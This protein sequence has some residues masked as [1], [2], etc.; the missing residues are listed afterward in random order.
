MNN[1]FIYFCIIGT[2]IENTLCMRFFFF[3]ILFLVIA[4]VIQAQN[5]L[6][7]EAATPAINLEHKYRSTVIDGD[8][9]PVIDLRTAVITGERIF[10]DAEEER[11]YRRLVRDVRK[12][13]PFAKIAGNR[14]KE[15]HALVEDKNRRQRKKL[16]K[17]AENNLK[18]EFKKDL[19]NLT[20]NQG[21]ILM[22][23]IDRET[24]NSSYDL[25]KIYR[26][27]LSAL[28]WQSFAVIYDDKL[29]MKVR[30]D[31]DGEDKLIE[32][33]VLM[34]DRQEL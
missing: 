14:I 24:G 23:L 25:V 7:G 28:F 26:G 19:E 33:I 15:Y 30:Y 13:Y 34:I 22:K 31:K 2:E 12:A 21:R 16:M 9:I 3:I 6:L 18:V 4:P 1:K 17:E 11:R 5:E 27:T 29:N 10:K 32:E 20:V 8:T